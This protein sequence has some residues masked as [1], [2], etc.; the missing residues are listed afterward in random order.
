MKIVYCLNRL[1]IIGGIER[2]TVIK[3]NA[4]S[5]LPGNEVYIIL[6]DNH[7]DD[8]PF[9]L[10][11]AVHLI[12]MKIDYSASWNP[13][14]STIVNYLNYR[15]RKKEHKI[16][17]E[18][19]L[20]SISP[21]VVVSTGTGEKHMLASMKNRQWKLIIEQHG[22]RYHHVK[23]AGSLFQKAL[24]LVLGYY[25]DT[26]CLRRCD[27][28]VLLTEGERNDNWRGWKNVTV[29]P[30]PVS[31]KCDTPS[32]LDEKR[33]VSVGRLDHMKNFPSLINVFKKV[34]VKHPDWILEI[35]GDGPEMSAI[36]EQIAHY[37]L[38]NVVLMKGF[39]DNIQNV[40]TQS[41]IFAFPSLSEGMPMSLLEAMECGLPVV[42]YDCP[43][44]PR[45]IITDGSDGYLIP[46]NDENM[47]ADRICRLIED[48]E[49][50]KEMGQAAKIKAQSYQIESIIDRWMNLFNELLGRK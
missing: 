29:M 45:E 17:L 49:L 19:L 41:S 39:T 22:E 28:F 35:Y 7:G 24:T 43:H 15:K 31:F 48:E 10:S 46:V 6:S 37:G 34:N 18:N 11:P 12:D 13:Q 21:D 44:G 32:G 40:M 20:E 14:K 47:M 9:E 36:Q 25:H 16:Q 5:Q 30:N 42:S 1:N 4:F 8:V 26:Y 38:Q 3:A 33:V 2:V 27:R 23:H 50:R